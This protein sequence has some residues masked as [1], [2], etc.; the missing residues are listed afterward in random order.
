M[1]SE[2]L[3]L[4][5]RLFPNRLLRWSAIAGLWTLIGIMSA[6]HWSFFPMGDYPYS[7][8]ELYRVKIVLWYIWGAVTP[9]ILHLAFRYNIERPINW[10][11]V[12]TLVTASLVITLLYLFVYAE[13]LIFNISGDL[14]TKRYWGMFEFVISRH[15]TFYYLA[16]WTLVGLEHAITYYRR[17][18]E[19]QLQA[20]QLETLLAQAHL[21]ALRS[22]LQPHFLFNSLHS[23]VALIR[24]KRTEEAT[25]MV[26]GLSDLLRQTLVHMDRNQVTLEQELDLLHRYIA[27]EKMRFSDRLEVREE[28]ARETLVA[29][30]PSFLLQPLVENAIRHGIERKVGAGTITIRSSCR[31]D[32]LTLAIIDDGPGPDGA[33]RDNGSGM[34]LQATRERLER[35]Y[36]DRYELTLKQ[37]REGG[38]A[39][40]VS[41]PLEFE[42]KD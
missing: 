1:P 37:E 34:G 42:A 29:R 3:A 41:F 27:I 38:T 22:R 30:V 25:A 11:R 12:A 6:S 24:S 19:R 40:V 13:L 5:R 17:S 36:R 2:T 39:T 31:D 14:A 26:T 7:W 28:I 4:I 21:A 10:S 32:R 9:L 15:S 16:F 8:W 20:S 23:V 33:G 35:M 18:H